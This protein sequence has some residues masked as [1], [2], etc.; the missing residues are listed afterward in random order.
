[1]LHD[2]FPLV[3]KNRGYCL[4]KHNNRVPKLPKQC[5]NFLGKRSYRQKAYLKV[6]LFYTLNWVK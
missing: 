3:S 4:I 6:H 1:M 2:T 5:V